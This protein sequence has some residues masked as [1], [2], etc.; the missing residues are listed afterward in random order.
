MW[1]GIDTDD[2]SCQLVVN[3]SEVFT[4]SP[5][6]F[7]YCSNALEASI[8]AR[9]LPR[10]PAYSGQHIYTTPCEWQLSVDTY[11]LSISQSAY[12]YNTL[13]VATVCGYLGPRIS[14]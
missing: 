1:Q 10:T 8:S 3:A 9:L 7:H 14:Q 5:F 2:S 11:D 6:V 13:K 4:V 12:L